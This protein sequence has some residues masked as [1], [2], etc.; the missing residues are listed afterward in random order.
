MAKC[1]SRRETLEEIH[2]RS[3]D[4]TNEIAQA[5]A[6]EADSKFLVSSNDDYDD[7]GIQSGS[8]DEAGPEGE[9]A[10]KGETSVAYI[11]SSFLIVLFFM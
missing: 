11:G 10:P 3:F 2:A 7:E 8:D 9:A 4:L 5:R 1:Q 6:L